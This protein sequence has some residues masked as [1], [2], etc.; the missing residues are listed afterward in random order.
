MALNWT[1]AL[2][3]SSNP[4][5]SAGSGLVFEKELIYVGHFTKGDQEW[6]VTEES[7]DH[8]ILE[9]SK[10]SAHG[11]KIVLPVEHTF[12]PEKNRGYVTALSK[13]PNS[14]G[15]MALFGR[16]EFRDLEAA[17][18]AL[19]TD[20]SIY[21]PPTYLMG[22]GYNAIRPITHVA[23][24]T[25]PVVPGLSPF[26]TLAASFAQGSLMVLIEL[27]KKLGL[28]VPEGA[29]DAAVSE[30]ILK[31]FTDAKKAA[32]PAPATDPAVAASLS[33]LLSLLK[34]DTK[35]ASDPN[36]A[37]ML[38]M[39]TDNRN[40]KI[41]SLVSTFKLSPAEATAWKK[42]YTPTAMA[43]STTDGFEQAYSLALSRTPITQ[44][45]SRTATQSANL[46]P[47][48]NPMIA[49]ALA[50]QKAAG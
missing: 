23:L 25:Y 49:D 41:D 42:A 24:T 50:R 18:L 47:A 32:T 30:M 20:V 28:E 35:P 4:I 36:E 11:F 43:L 1:K 5:D 48:T 15:V 40:L 46:D 39:I 12:D 44:P 19:S 38:S 2:F 9:F 34:K 8:W 31:A 33:E 37:I 10:M 14:R 13:K 17:K 7:I 3:L 45:G 26:E 6:D 27:A 29:D 16:T 22:N 21:S